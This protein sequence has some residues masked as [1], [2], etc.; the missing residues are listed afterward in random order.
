MLCQEAGRRHLEFRIPQFQQGA[1]SQAG[2]LVLGKKLL[3]CLRQIQDFQ[4]GADGGQ[5]DPELLR[6]ASLAQARIEQ[7]LVVQGF[8]QRVGVKADLVLNRHVKHLFRLV[9]LPQDHRHQ[10]SLIAQVGRAVPA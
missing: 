2:Q 1:G 5:R 9:K 4:P 3:Y 10:G 7:S 8:A 6:D